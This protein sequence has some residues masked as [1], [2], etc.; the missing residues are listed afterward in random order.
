MRPGLRWDSGQIP[1]SCGPTGTRTNAGPLSGPTSNAR[2]GTPAGRRPCS[3]RWTGWTSTRAPDIPASIRFTGL[4]GVGKTVLLRKL[5]DAHREFAC[6][7][8]L[9]KTDVYGRRGQFA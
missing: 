9:Y 6:C 1:T 8:D 3:A 2:M 7:V 5:D 4:R